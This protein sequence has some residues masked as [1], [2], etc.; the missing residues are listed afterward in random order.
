M[1]AGQP[2]AVIGR[3]ALYDEIASGGMATVHFGRLLGPVGFARTVAIK[4]LHQQFAKDPEF[5]SMFLDEAR[6]AARIRHPNVVPTLDVVALSGEL[7]LVMDYV[8]GVSLSRLLRAAAAQNTRMPVEVAAAIVVGALHG[9]HAA[10]EARSERGL[11]LGIVHR[12][13]SPQ[14]V[15]VGSDGQPRV[16]DFGVA[17]ASWRIQTTRDGQ[18]KGKLSYM[19]PE[20]INDG[21]VGPWTDVYAAGIVFWETL[22]NQRL[23]KTGDSAAILA[24]FT[25]NEPVSPPSTYNDQVTPEL[26]QVVL[27][28][29]ESE[30]TR[31]FASAHDMADAIEETVKVA[32][33]SAVARWVQ[34]V[35]HEELAQHAALI[36][37][38]ENGSTVSARPGSEDA[39]ALRKMLASISEGS[40]AEVPVTRTAETVVQSSG[41]QSSRSQISM[42]RSPGA[43]QPPRV[44]HRWPFRFGAGAAALAGAIALFVGFG[45]SKTSSS[46]A[47]PA[48]TERGS[49]PSQPS[50][51]LAAAPV[52]PPATAQAPPSA[53]AK[54]DAVP[55]SASS[56][57]AHPQATAIKSVSAGATPSGSKAVAAASA[58]GTVNCNP[59]YIVDSRG[60]RHLKLACVH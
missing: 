10:H 4:R 58:H 19:A 32:S 20:Q 9:L 44:L 8:H 11:P 50:S 34:S 13:V 35:V 30:H 24:R 21:A 52:S 5:V 48:P 59:P 51:V 7:F 12:D 31:R 57:K 41:E 46:S 6:L 18:I 39:P 27:R 54:V 45:H 26:D 56:A 25:K 2:A 38:I 36:A 3:Y 15:I 43:S 53:S 22:A 40:D 60:V 29:L 47:P 55:T 49:A 1:S 16:L 28:A 42:T 17:K 33:S 37:E 14:N 23:F